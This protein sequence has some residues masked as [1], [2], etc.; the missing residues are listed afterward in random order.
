MIDA[1][2]DDTALKEKVFAKL[3]TLDDLSAVTLKEL[4]RSVE[5]SMKLSKR[6]LLKEPYRAQIIKW[7]E[8]YQNYVVSQATNNSADIEAIETNNVRKDT[9]ADIF[10]DESDDQNDMEEDEE[11]DSDDDFV[12]SHGG[13]RP[14]IGRGRFTPDEDKLIMKL[15]EEHMEANHVDESAFIVTLRSTDSRPKSDIWKQIY[16]L[17]PNRPYRVSVLAFVSFICFL[18]SIHFHYSVYIIVFELLL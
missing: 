8:E 18:M 1:N 13:I 4:T 5:K 16:S 3:A 17:F 15:C 7:V 11:D 9:V 10:S 12:E 14:H 2:M 6:S